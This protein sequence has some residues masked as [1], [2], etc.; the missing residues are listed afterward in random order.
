MAFNF[1]F[2]Y[3]LSF[4]NE[5]RLPLGHKKGKLYIVHPSV[6]TGWDCRLKLLFINLEFPVR[7]F[8]KLPLIMSLPSN[9]RKK[10]TKVIPYQNILGSSER[11]TAHQTTVIESIYNNQNYHPL[12]TTNKSTYIDAQISKSKIKITAINDHDIIKHH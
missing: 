2:F 7:A 1:L 4:S 5:Q 12:Y 6:D 10:K 9:N 11:C 8:S 3:Y